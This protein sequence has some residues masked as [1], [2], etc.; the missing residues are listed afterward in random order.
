MQTDL[1]RII[2][3]QAD[4]VRNRH[5]FPA[6]WRMFCCVTRLARQREHDAG[7]APAISTINNISQQYRLAISG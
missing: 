5:S 2:T 3:D 4:S 1:H 7:Q 6:I